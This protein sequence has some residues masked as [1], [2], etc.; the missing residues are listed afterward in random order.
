MFLLLLIE[1]HS[2]PE[3]NIGTPDQV[4]RSYSRRGSSSICSNVRHSAW[5]A[6]PRQLPPML[7]EALTLPTNAR[8]RL[9]E[10]ECILPSRPGFREKTPENPICP[11]HFR[12][13]D[14]PLI[15]A[16]LMAQRQILRLKRCTRPEHR[17]HETGTQSDGFNHIHSDDASEKDVLRSRKGNRWCCDVTN[18][19]E[20]TA[21]VSPCLPTR[22]SIRE[23]HPQYKPLN[24]EKSQAA[25]GVC[26]RTHRKAGSVPHPQRAC[27]T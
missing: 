27:V 23:P 11:L 18:S 20:S 13:L 16:Q 15:N 17:G 24:G 3:F 5:F 21:A 2:L 7:F 25:A 10:H 19:T 14:T 26:R 8:I 22:T 1:D 4:K 12:S 9:H 6:S